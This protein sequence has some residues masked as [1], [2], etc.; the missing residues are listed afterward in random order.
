MD[1]NMCW[2]IKQI[3]RNNC[4]VEQKHE[5][6]NVRQLSCSELP[7]PILVK[8]NSDHLQVFI[9]SD[10]ENVYS[11]NKFIIKLNIPLIHYSFRYR[12]V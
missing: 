4:A 1:R 5:Y 12:F 2:F 10:T 9:F 3:V 11:S 8:K 7:I 6:K